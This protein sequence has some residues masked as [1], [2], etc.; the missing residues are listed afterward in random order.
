MATSKE[1]QKQAETVCC[2]EFNPEQYDEKEIT[3]NDK[4]FLK[5]HV[6]SFLHMPLNFG[7]VMKR[8]MEK[9]DAVNGLPG[10]Y[11]M[12]SDE[13]SLWG[14]D[15]YIAVK[16]EIPG[17]I[18]YQLSGTFLTKVFEGPYKNIGKWKE[19]MKKYVASK[20]KQV[21]KLYY[22]YTTCP[23]CA[24]HYGKNYIVIFAE[25]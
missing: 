17:A 18:M 22:Y 16:K 14:S 21:K 8:A 2:P 1:L 3:F 11:L 12:L 5:D 7:S 24:K 20:G 6:V 15:I 10:D 4:L 9:I 13:K 25:V 19:E 23:K